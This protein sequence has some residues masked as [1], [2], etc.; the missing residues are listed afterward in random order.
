[1][2]KPELEEFIALIRK[3]ADLPGDKPISADSSL[4]DLGVDSIRMMFLVNEI[5]KQYDVILEVVNLYEAVSLRDLHQ[6]IIS[7]I[8]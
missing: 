1:M 8:A 4:Y 7:R 6:I 3:T 2:Q 5:D